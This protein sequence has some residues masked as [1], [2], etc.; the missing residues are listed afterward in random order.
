ML[1]RTR[2]GL[3]GH[4]PAFDHPERT[5]REVIATLRARSYNKVKCCLPMVFAPPRS[6]CSTCS[7]YAVFSDANTLKSHGCSLWEVWD[8]RRQ[9]T[10]LFS[11][12]NV[13]TSADSCGAKPSQI[14]IRGL[15]FARARVAGSK[16]FWIQYRLMVEFVYPDSLQAK[17]QPGVSWVTQ[18]LRR[19]A[20][21]QQWVGQ[22]SDHRLI[23]TQWR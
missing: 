3:N 18:V 16:T 12:Q 1:P 7:R 17:C 9:S 13:I 14:R 23:Y 11:K 21:G 5:L 4:S 6:S 10:M 20:A 15:P 22:G 19:V 2:S 8:G